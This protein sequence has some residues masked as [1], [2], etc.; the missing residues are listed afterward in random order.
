MKVEIEVL[1]A[2]LIAAVVGGFA[3][4]VLYEAGMYKPLTSKEPEHSALGQCADCHLIKQPDHGCS[5]LRG[6]A[7]ID[8]TDPDRDRQTHQQWVYEIQVTAHERLAPQ[9]MK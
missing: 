6:Q 2:A 7:W 4:L 8:C 3:L 9:E 5:E 1:I